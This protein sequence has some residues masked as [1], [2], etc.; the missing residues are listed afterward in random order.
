MGFEELPAHEVVFEEG[1]VAKKFYVVISG[2]VS[3]HRRNESKSKC[4]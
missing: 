3:C 1:D 2:S 4:L